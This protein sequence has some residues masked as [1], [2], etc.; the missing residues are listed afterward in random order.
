MANEYQRVAMR[1]NDYQ[2]LKLLAA[3][4]NLSRA[5][6]DKLPLADFLGGMLDVEW[7]K[8]RERGLVSDEMVRLDDAVESF[9]E[10]VYG[11]LTEGA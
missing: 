4:A 2:K 7:R 6:N 11:E 10:P 5:T 9:R 3:L 1:P 8:A